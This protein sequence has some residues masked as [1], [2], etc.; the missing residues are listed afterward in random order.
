MS[1]RCGCGGSSDLS[2]SGPLLYFLAAS[3]A[4][5]AEKDRAD[6][7]A[8]GT[9]DN[10]K[11]ATG[12]AAVKAAG[13]GTL[14]LS[15]GDFNLAAQVSIAG[16]DDLEIETDIV[17]R[18][19]GPGNTR[20][21]AASGLAS[22]I[23]IT[24]AARVHLSD[25]GISVVGATNGISSARTTTPA[26]GDRA[27]WYSTFKR[28]QVTGPYDG[29]HTGW[30]F[31][32]GSAYDSLFEQIEGLGVGNGVRL[33]NQVTAQSPGGLVLT[34][35]HMDLWGT[36]RIGYSID[37]VVAAAS[38]TQILFQECSAVGDGSG[39]KGYWFGGSGESSHN[40]VVG[41]SLDVFDTLVEVDRG[42]GNRFDLGYCGPRGATALTGFKFGVNAWNNRV[43][44]GVVR[45]ST[46][47]FTLLNDAGTVF[48]N[49]PNQVR[50]V[51]LNALGGTTITQTVQPRTV[52]EGIS[53]YGAGTATAV[54]KPPAVKTPNRP[55]TLV[56]A[57][58][59]AVDASL[60]NLFRVTM[61]GNRAIGVP[62]NPTDGQEM[63]IEMLAS[64]GA[65]TP[66]FTAGAGGFVLGNIVITAIA[67]ATT[68][69]AKC[70][71][72]ATAARWR[73]VE[74]WKNYA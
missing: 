46:G 27:F 11:I 71:Y 32:L 54:T 2:R 39:C 59:V 24:A 63:L 1:R 69:I 51:A 9:A 13:G 10:V 38:M 65:R 4:P 40:R 47:T 48:P 43:S 45:V 19:A 30:A 31:S 70:V 67:S 34:R 26:A 73:V 7:V 23:N 62:T 44:A 50:D 3:N 61:A 33:F 42:E 20:L 5:Q 29:S 16:F 41:G 53:N 49:Q 74:I 15:Q 66:S 52:T 36:N 18:G 17:M 60:G 55:I 35:C 72:N 28:I 22:A 56:D 14:L 25:F 37:A 12:L 64:G 68:D 6:A 57:A 8:D 58:T 21:A